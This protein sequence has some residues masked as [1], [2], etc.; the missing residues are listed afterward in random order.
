MLTT[1]AYV[2]AWIIALLGAGGLLLVLFRITRGWRPVALRVVTRTVAAIWLLMPAVV[3]PEGLQV[4]MAPALIVLLFELTGGIDDALRIL[5]PMIIL[6][7]AAIPVALA[8]HWGFNR[9]QL[10]RTRRQAQ[11]GRDYA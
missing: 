3:D 8:A 2:I 11:Q 5:E 10:Q 4:S 9:W 1:K 6:T 7:A